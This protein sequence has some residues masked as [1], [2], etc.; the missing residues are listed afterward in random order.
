MGTEKNVMSINQIFYFWESDRDWE[1]KNK[2][3]SESKSG[4]NMSD[5]EDI[6]YWRVNEKMNEKKH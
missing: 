4:E 5:G 3:I 6:E 2:I 1:K